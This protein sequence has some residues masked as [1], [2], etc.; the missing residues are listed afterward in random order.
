MTTPRSFAIRG[1]ALLPIVQG[2]MGVGV[3]AHRLAG[4]V[5]RAGAVGTIASIDLRHHHADLTEQGK[6][7]RDRDELNRL[8]FI[9]LDREIG[10]ALDI[11]AGHGLVAVNVMKAVDAH[12]AYVRQACDSGA[13]AI[14][15]GAGLPLDL[16]EL[17]EGYPEVALIPILSDAR[18]AAIVLK[19]LARKGR[20][21]DAMVIEHPQYAG[22]HLGAPN[23]ADLANP[24]FDLAEVLPAIFRVFDDLGI[25]RAQ[26]PVIVGGGINSHE[27]VRA[28]LALGAAAVQVGT[29][30]AVTEEGDAHL[31]FK[32]VLLDAKPEDIVTFMSVAG[33]PARAVKTPWLANYLK[34]ESK[35]QAVAKADPNRC[36]IGLHCLTQCGLRD[37]LKKAGQFCIDSQLVAAL[38]GE[39]SKGL[40]FRGSESLPFANAI[41][42]VQEL[43]DYLLTGMKPDLGGAAA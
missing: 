17:T 15:M 36:A 43:I 13:Q 3:S 42:S 39:V 31:N 9:A 37:G 8:N 5:A 21:P 20:L 29:P 6:H 34:R 19:K 27:K 2:G 4:A 1:R 30:F 7:C 10:A 32:R 28:A 23:P 40:F 25:A 38:K 33:L 35:L 16:A 14:V 26:I 22:G 24:R 18:G 11:A 12:P 41:R